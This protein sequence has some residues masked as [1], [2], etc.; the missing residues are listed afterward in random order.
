M[1]ALVESLVARWSLRLAQIRNTMSE[2]PLLTHRK[3]TR[4]ISTLNLEHEVYGK[5]SRSTVLLN[6]APSRIEHAKSRLTK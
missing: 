1:Y 2:R 4:A 6:R 3:T 5:T